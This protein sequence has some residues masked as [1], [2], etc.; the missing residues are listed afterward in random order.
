M[1]ARDLAA[2]SFTKHPR[3]DPRTTLQRLT[4]TYLVEEVLEAER[5]RE[6]VTQRGLRDQTSLA[7]GTISSVLSAG[8]RGKVLTVERPRPPKGHRVDGSA[9]GRY[10]LRSDAAV[11]IGV[12]VSVHGVW[13]DM[14]DTTGDRPRHVKGRST[15]PRVGLLEDPHWVINRID[16]HL[17]ALLTKVDATKQV[18]AVYVCFPGPVH[19][20]TYAGEFSRI[21]AEADDDLATTIKD[22]FAGCVHAGERPPDVYIDSDAHVGALAEA[23]AAAKDGEQSPGTILHIRI[24]DGIRT[25]VVSGGQLYQGPSERSGQVEHQ[26]ADIRVDEQERLLGGVEPWACPECERTDCLAAL[27]SGA[28]LHRVAYPKAPEDG[29]ARLLRDARSGHERAREVL[30]I[31]GVVIG[32]SLGPLV[33]FLDVDEV[34][35]GGLLGDDPEAYALVEGDLKRGLSEAAPGREAA[36]QRAR[37]SSE[38]IALAAARLGMRYSLLPHLVSRILSERQAPDANR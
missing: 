8:K 18:A 4:I 38:G 5:A 23:A 25:G 20:G 28:A 30:G 35:V 1:A 13:V 16:Q 3:E 19:D 32:R 33:T 14:V 10:W 7:S 21:W 29:F 9:P 22:R 15:A 6:G 34:A 2:P 24:S 37:V 17:R 36:L 31:A 27:V 26:R 12:D 11:A